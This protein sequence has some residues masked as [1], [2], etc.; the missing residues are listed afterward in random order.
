MTTGRT[1]QR[2]FPLR[3]GSLHARRPGVEHGREAG[4]P[5]E[6]S[7]L[8]DVDAQGECTKSQQVS[9]I[10]DALWNGIRSDNVM[11]WRRQIT[12]RS[13]AATSTL[14]VERLSGPMPAVASTAQASP[15]VKEI[16]QREFRSTRSPCHVVFR[17]AAHGTGCVFP[18]V[19]VDSELR[20]TGRVLVS[21]TQ[22]SLQQPSRRKETARF[23]AAATRSV[24]AA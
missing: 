20:A 12:A 13:A 8:R 5:S 10:R 16:S 19:S 9:S 7:S 3:A 11:S 22:Q 24:A 17:P 14:P 4:F 15:R 1:C 2:F 6:A 18:V 23:A 21:V